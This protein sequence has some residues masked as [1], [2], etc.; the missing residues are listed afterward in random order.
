ML[1]SYIASPLDH[2]TVQWIR[3]LLVPHGFACH[4][5]ALEHAHFLYGHKARDQ[6]GSHP[7]PSLIALARYLLPLTLSFVVMVLLLWALCAV[8]MDIHELTARAERS[9]TARRL[10]IE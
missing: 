5:H 2:S 7:E 6:P 1:F 4:V 3:G 10:T 9:S 8:A